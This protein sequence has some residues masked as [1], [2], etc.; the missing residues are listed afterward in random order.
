MKLDPENEELVN[1]FRLGRINFSN[2]GV[3]NNM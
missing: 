2:L 3:R 1:A